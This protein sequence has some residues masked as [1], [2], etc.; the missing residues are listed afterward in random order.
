VLKIQKFEIIIT[1][2]IKISGIDNIIVQ[3]YTTDTF[4]LLA[5]PLSP[6]QKAPL[7]SFITSTLG[8]GSTDLGLLLPRLVRCSK[9]SDPASQHQIKSIKITSK[10]ALNNRINYYLYYTINTNTSPEFCLLYA[11]VNPSRHLFL[12]SLLYYNFNI[13]THFLFEQRRAFVIISKLSYL[14]ALYSTELKCSFQPLLFQ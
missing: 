7:R 13:F 11:Y 12:N 1:Y 10:A 3:T 8:A 4:L 2:I 14:P 5:P 9:S 6:A